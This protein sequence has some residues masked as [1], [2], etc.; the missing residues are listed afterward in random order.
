MPVITLTKLR[1][2]GSFWEDWITLK[3]SSMLSALIRATI[4][5]RRASSSPGV[6]DRTEDEKNSTKFRWKIQ[7][8]DEGWRREK[9]NLDLQLWRPDRI[10]RARCVDW[11]KWRDL[12]WMQPV[13]V[14]LSAPWLRDQGSSS[15]S[16]YS[17]LAFARTKVIY[18]LL[19]FALVIITLFVFFGRTSES[20]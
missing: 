19:L 18:P 2:T 11:E 4:L 12:R 13:G 7:Q 5:H 10:E 14:W 9:K 16:P 15:L 17:V 20:T 8:Q 3:A 6:I 1:S